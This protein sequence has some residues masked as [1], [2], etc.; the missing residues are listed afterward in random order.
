[1]PAKAQTVPPPFEKEQEHGEKERTLTMEHLTRKKT[2]PLRGSTSTEKRGNRV[3]LPMPLS[4]EVGRFFQRKTFSMQP[5]YQWGNQREDADDIAK[6]QKKVT[7]KKG[8]TTAKR[9]CE[10]TA[11]RKKR[12]PLT[13][14][15]FAPK[16]RKKSWTGGVTIWNPGA[17]TKKQGKKRQ[18]AGGMSSFTGFEADSRKQSNKREINAVAKKK[19]A[20]Y[21][22]E[23]K[24]RD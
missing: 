17:Q 1:M 20:M 16:Q 13:K 7:Q 4:I 5:E 2:M 3:R 10:S 23:G 21:W 9:K 12:S 6:P 18:T 8:M 24:C 15:H 19:K 11:A 22:K 14:K